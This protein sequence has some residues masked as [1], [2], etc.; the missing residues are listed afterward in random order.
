[1]TKLRVGLTG[2]IGSG[3]SAVA[4]LLAE[5]GATVIDADVLARE[6]VAPGTDGLRAIGRLWPQAIGADGTLDRPRLAGIV[7]ADGPAREQ[8]N[9]I[10]HPRVRERGAELERQ[11]RTGS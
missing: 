10:T 5:R 3:K 7:F 1:M 2:G 9:A 6:V 11:R 4:S 8:L